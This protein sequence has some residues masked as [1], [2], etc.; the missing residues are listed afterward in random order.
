MIHPQPTT[1]LLLLYSPIEL[2]P[3]E[4]GSLRAGRLGP[5]LARCR[6]RSRAVADAERV[7]SGGS[8]GGSGSSGGGSGSNRVIRPAS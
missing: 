6:V 1:A 5:L 4:R 3:R 7:G 8:G 2:A